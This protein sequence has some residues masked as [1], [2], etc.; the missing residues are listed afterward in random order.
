MLDMELRSFDSRWKDDITDFIN[1]NR[2]IQAHIQGIVYDSERK[3]FTLFYW[4]K[5]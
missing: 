3:C 2:I 4:G 1:A 5:D